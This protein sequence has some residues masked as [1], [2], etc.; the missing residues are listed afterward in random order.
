MFNKIEIS[1]VRFFFWLVSTAVYWGLIFIAW[2]DS[3][4]KVFLWYSI[5]A[6][7]SERKSYSSIMK[8]LTELEGH[9]WE[10]LSLSGPLEFEFFIVPLIMAVVF[11]MA[12]LMARKDFKAPLKGFVTLPLASFLCYITVS[13]VNLVLVSAINGVIY[14]VLLK[15]TGPDFFMFMIQPLY[16]I[17]PIFRSIPGFLSQ[18]LYLVFIGSVL[19]APISRY[20]VEDEDG[21]EGEA[22]EDVSNGAGDDWDKSACI[23]EMD[24]LIRILDSKFSEQCLIHEVRADIAEYINRPQ[25]VSEDVKL[26]IPYYKIVLT[27][28][29]NSLR[30]IISENRNR[31]VSDSA[32]IFIVNELERMSYVS[33]SD[34]DSMRKFV[35][36]AALDS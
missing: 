34:A 3:R 6:Q 10:A 22:D 33:A 20:E 16:L 12:P 27:E 4:F 29:K 14:Y 8:N 35:Q 23:M 2:W 19:S 21:Y 31:P 15:K 24:R 1:L 7:L 11:F 25:R 9:A 30:R 32:F 13:L 17:F 18:C 5:F 36:P 28:A 26:G